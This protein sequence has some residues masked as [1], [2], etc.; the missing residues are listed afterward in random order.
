VPD[1][2]LDVAPFEVVTPIK[3]IDFFDMKSR[4]ILCKPGLQARLVP[5]GQGSATGGSG[6]EAGQERRRWR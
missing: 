6:Q 5:G 3:T 1:G 2:K 4:G